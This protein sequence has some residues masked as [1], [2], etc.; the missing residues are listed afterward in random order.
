VLPSGTI[1]PPRSPRD[2]CGHG[3]RIAQLIAAA[4]GVELIDARIFDESLRSSAVRAAAAIDWLIVQRARL[5]NLSFGLELDRD[6]LR[7]ACARAVE[8]GVLIV[9][10]PSSY[11]GI[12]RATGD[13]RC[14][15]G[16]ISWLAGPLADFGG[17]VRTVD[18]SFRGASVG[19][20]NVSAA[21][22]AWLTAN[23]HGTND[24]ALAA[25]RERAEYRGPERRIR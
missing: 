4:P 19:C 2:H 21:I 20:A 25:L 10:F 15:P 9:V 24:E 13:A 18:D 11:P 3:T 1:E 5:I 8:R 14:N 17:C 6:V 16:E 23:P 7:A 22:A 12:V